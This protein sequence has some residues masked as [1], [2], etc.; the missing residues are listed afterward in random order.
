MLLSAAAAARAEPLPEA[1]R[2]A[3]AERAHPYVPDVPPV[4][5]ARAE[6][7]SLDEL[8]AYADAH[9]PAVL[10]ARARA[11][12][13]H[14]DVVAAGPR[15]PANPEL[16]LGA[17]G[18]TVSGRTALEFE[19]SLDQRLEIGGEPRLRRRAARA[20]QQTA[21][22]AVDEVRWETHVEVH[23]LH[24]DLL[25]AA[26]RRVQAERFIAFST[27]LHEVAE[28]QVAAGESSPIIRLVTGADLAETREA[29]IAA[30]QTEASLRTRLAA[31]VGWPADTPLALRGELAPIRRAPATE[32]LLAVM[33]EHHPQV[34][35]RE[36]AVASQRARVELERREAWPEP[37]VG[38]SYG[39]E[40]APGPGPA[41]H[42]WL[43]NLSVPLPMVHANQGPR[44]RAL[45]E[46]RLADREREASVIALRSALEQAARALDAAV[47]RVELYSEEVMPQLERNLALLGRAYE[48]GE[49]DI[50]QV[51]QTRQR[52]LDASSRYLDARIAYFETAATLEGLVGTELWTDA[53]VAP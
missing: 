49:V 3:P 43:V 23:R 30:V 13:A 21:Q 22:A 15:L 40:A 36:L 4:D 39:R 8:L 18:R 52:L 53:E 41:A 29:G 31:L 25:L 48:L 42:V 11:D 28:R 34:R 45:A 33:A 20:E 27:S 7:L 10:S 47:D 35:A 44:E 51:S 37:T 9:A 24:A 26:E 12:L 32:A 38:L 50:H 16:G 1:G 46:L 6:P 2:Y 14:A 17:G 5:P 19:V